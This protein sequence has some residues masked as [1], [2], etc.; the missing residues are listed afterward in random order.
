LESDTAGDE[1]FEKQGLK[2]VAVKGGCRQL[3]LH[4]GVE[5]VILQLSFLRRKLLGRDC[6]VFV[7]RMLLVYVQCRGRS[8][9]RRLEYVTFGKQA[10]HRSMM[11]SSTKPELELDPF[12]NRR[13][14]CHI[15]EGFFLIFQAAL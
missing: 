2:S 13:P 12:H 9:T 4:A 3:L 14:C 11:A 6:P 10:F 1:P 7:D 15:Q 5:G 8:C